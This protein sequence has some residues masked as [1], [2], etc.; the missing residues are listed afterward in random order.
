M[1]CVVY[2][3]RAANAEPL[4]LVWA[5]AGP[6]SSPV[7]DSYL[8]LHCCHFF[9]ATVTANSCSGLDLEWL[10]D[11]CCLPHLRVLED[12]IIPCTRHL[13][14]D[15][16]VPCNSERRYRS[17]RAFFTEEVCSSSRSVVVSSSLSPPLSSEF[18]ICLGCVG[19]VLLMMHP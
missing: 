2:E 17:F 5:T 7:F 1:S 3:C 9:M 16:R 11:K 10:L 8:K 12:A 6:H 13:F 4:P 19:I 18:N 15:S 14:L